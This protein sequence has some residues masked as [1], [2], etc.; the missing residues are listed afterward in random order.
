MNTFLQILLGGALIVT[1]IFLILLVLVQRG[2][3]GGLAGALGGMGGSSA[4]GTKAGDTFTRITIVAVIL[5]IALCVV[6][7]LA[8]RQTTD[9]F[10][11][12]GIGGAATTGEDPV[13][14]LTVPKGDAAPAG[15]AGTG[16]NAAAD[17]D[18]S[19]EGDEA[20]EGDR[21]GTEG[22]IG[23]GAAQSAAPTP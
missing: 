15:A 16:E 21:L 17:P 18:R 11:N 14:E 12:S 7:M 4:L 6:T 3:G 19:D 9:Q 23:E 10:G 5:W 1:S 22:A 2:R 8:L 20:L 13:G